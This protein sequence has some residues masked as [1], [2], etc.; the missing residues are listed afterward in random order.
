MAL[1]IN[2]LFAAVITPAMTLGVFDRVNGHEPKSAPPGNTITAS[3]Y[4]D[5]FGPM[6]AQSGVDRTTMGLVFQCRVQ[7][8]MLADPPDAIDP[9]LLSAVS[10]LMGAYHGNFDLDVADTELDLLG[11]WWAGG[12]AARAGY[13]TQD[14][15]MYRALILSIPV[16]VNDVY[17]QVR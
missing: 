11:R 1:D 8:G 4:L 16:I 15:N 14:G 10:E 12:V 3:Y 5:F 13:V 2:A 9:N 7:T 6:Q 17:L